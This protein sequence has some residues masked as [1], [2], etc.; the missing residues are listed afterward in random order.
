MGGTPPRPPP[1]DTKVTTCKKNE[2][3]KILLGHF[4][5]TN[6]SVPDSHLPP[7]TPL[8]ILPRL[9][10]SDYWCGCRC[11]SCLAQN[12]CRYGFIEVKFE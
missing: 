8:L 1:L 11:F 6:F 3:H 10:L 7:P 2:I 5:Y 9:T 4:W 12:V